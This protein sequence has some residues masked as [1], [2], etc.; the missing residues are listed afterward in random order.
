MANQPMPSAADDESPSIRDIWEVGRLPALFAIITTAATWL[1]WYYTST[2]CTSELAAR[3][4]C[5]PAEIARYINV[6]IFG[7]MLTYS[8]IAAAAG[9]VWNYN[10]FT[11]MRAQIAAERQRADAALQELAQYRQQVEEERRQVEEERRLAAEERQ[12]RLEDEFRRSEE[13]RRTMMQENSEL[14][15]AMLAALTELTAEIGR[16]RQ[17]RNGDE[18]GE[19]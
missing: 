8:A 7:R 15:R 10:M 17:Q 6:D 18:A 3:T 4:I 9:G 5:N 16:L 13:E 19:R 11:K 14:N 12:R 2:P 1:I